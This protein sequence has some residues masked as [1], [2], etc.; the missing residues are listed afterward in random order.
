MYTNSKI[1]LE[2]LKTQVAKKIIKKKKIYLSISIIKMMKFPI[3][4]FRIGSLK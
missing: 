3:E 2:K 4:K 1:K